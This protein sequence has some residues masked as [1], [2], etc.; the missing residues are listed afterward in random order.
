[1]ALRAVPDHPK[2]ADFMARLRRPKYVALGCLEALW[3]FTGRF[4][5]QGN[6]GKYPDQA[7]E[8]WIGW[9]GEPG[10]L[11]AALVGAGW[12]DVDVNH[13]LLV[14]DWAQHADVMVHTTL[15][16]ECVCFG[17]GTTPECGRLNQRERERFHTWIEHEGLSPR[18]PGNQPKAATKQPQSSH[19]AA[20][21]SR[22]AAPNPKP[23]PEPEPEPEPKA[24]AP[25]K[26][27]PSPD[28]RAADFKSAFQ[29]A[30]QVANGI[31][32]PWDAKEATNLSRFLKSNPAVTLE[33]WQ[34]ILYHRSRSPVNQKASLSMWVARALAWLDAPADEWGKP[35]D[36]GNR[37]AYGN[38]GQART[39]GNLE[40]AR[41]AA[42]AIAGQGSDWA[43]GGPASIRE[44]G[45]AEAV[46]RTPV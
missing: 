43:G 40:A 1:M 17:D 34:H 15:A 18:R 9:D 20:E 2:F 39:N 31:P 35:I 37:N 6:I 5:P 46:Q 7:I 44:R 28:P 24:K 29:N 21:I 42:E 32:A 13:R 41:S 11:I 25:A 12:I 30:F 3:H 45:D 27:K 10:A 19:K 22:K 8:A 26:A 16:R 4:T 38:R 33:Q 23:E 36:G 14:H